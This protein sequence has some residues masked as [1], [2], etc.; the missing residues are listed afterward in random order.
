MLELT[1]WIGILLATVVS[2]G[3]G[4]AWYG[5]FA[6]PWVEAAGFTDEQ[7]RHVEANDQPVVYVIAAVCHLIMAIVLAAFIA[8][9]G[10]GIGSGFWTGMLAW[11]GF[12]ATSMCVNHRFQFR[13]WTLTAIDAGHYFVALIAQGL[14]LGWFIGP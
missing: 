12:V 5:G 6:K 1:D 13:P 10:G 14:I 7:L 8:S 3:I 11:L 4:A 2:M 9:R